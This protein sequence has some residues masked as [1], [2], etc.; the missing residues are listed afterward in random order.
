MIKVLIADDHPIVREGL[1]QVIEKGADMEVAGEALNGQE[2]LDKVY[3]EKWDV[4][5]LDFSMPGKTG[6]DVIKELRRERPKLPILVL[7]MYPEGELAPRLLKAGAA[8]YLNK[9]SAPR[10]LVHAIRKV[11]AGGKYVSP[12]LAEKLATDLTVPADKKPHDILS[13]REYQ[14]F[15]RL[16]AG[17]SVQEIADENSLSVKTVRTYRERIL[18][19]LKL[20]NDVEIAHFAIEHRLMQ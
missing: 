11:Y 19:K 4:V 17:R 2:V 13:D 20:K 14:V 3:A 9:E 15:L 5:I 6:L 12:A 16:A 18:E 1:K 7:S 10:E 8:G